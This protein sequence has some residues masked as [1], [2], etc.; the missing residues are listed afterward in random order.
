MTGAGGFL[1]GYVAREF[2]DQGWRVAGVDLVPESAM[3][4]FSGD[5]YCQSS[6]TDPRMGDL[7]AE[8]RPDACVHCAGSASVP[9]SMQ[10]PMA[11]FQANALMTATLLE[12]IRTSAHSCAFVLLSSAAVYGSPD[13]LPIDEATRIAPISSYGFHKLMAEQL[14]REYAILHGV[15]AASARIF[16][17]YGP[18]LKRQVLWDLCGKLLGGGEVLLQGTGAESRDFVH[19]TDIARAVMAIVEGAEFKGEAYNVASGAETS[20]SDL[21]LRIVA[22]LQLERDVRFDGVLPA[23]IPSR[24][25]AD[26]DRLRGLGFRPRISIDEG[27]REFAAWASTQLQPA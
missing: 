9:L 8:L 18:G 14:C 17:A 16:S 20:I 10:Q 2:R 25:Q 4:G 27:V 19:A 12:A 7:L 1:G 3:N 6:V 15:P 22:A 26:I 24:W 5:R 23:G 11:D 13:T 21:A